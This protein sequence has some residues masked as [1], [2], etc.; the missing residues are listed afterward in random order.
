MTL[1]KCPCNSGYRLAITIPQPC[2]TVRGGGEDASIVWGEQ[3][4]SD[5]ARMTL[6]RGQGSTITVPKSRSTI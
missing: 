5:R 2:A 4:T 3:R 1:S 6:Q